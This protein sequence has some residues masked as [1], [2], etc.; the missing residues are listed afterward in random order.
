MN[1]Q[2]AEA[3]ELYTIKIS[4]LPPELHAGTLKNELLARYDIIPSRIEILGQRATLWLNKESDAQKLLKGFSYLDKSYTPEVIVLSPSIKVRI[5]DL[6]EAQ[7]TTP[8]AEVNRVFFRH[9]EIYPMFINAI[10]NDLEI[11]ISNNEANKKIIE[12]MIRDNFI[13]GAGS[14]EMEHISDQEYKCSPL[15]VQVSEFLKF[16]IKDFKEDA[17]KSI[18][19]QPIKMTLY[20]QH[21]LRAETLTMDNDDLVVSVPKNADY[22]KKVNSIT[23]FTMKDIEYLIQV[24]K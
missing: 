9:N 15:V 20:I 17:F 5:K 22:E 7:R 23:K 8:F 21:G 1:I 10:G 2:A 16:R 18:S 3:D 24:E 11:E 12:G 6:P 13:T 14:Y 19:P 4:A